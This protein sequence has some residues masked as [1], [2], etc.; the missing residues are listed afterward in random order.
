MLDRV[1]LEIGHEP[2]DVDHRHFGCSSSA[3]TR[4]PS[5][6]RPERAATVRHRVLLL[7]CHLRKGTPVTLSGDEHRVVPESFRAPRFLGDEPLDVAE[8]GHLPAVGPV[9]QRHRWRSGR[10]VRRVG[11]AA[12]RVEQL[13]HVVGV[14]GRLPR[15]AGGPHPGR[16]AE[17]VDLEPGVVGEGREAGRLAQRDRLQPRVVFERDPGLVDVGHVGRAGHQL[18]RQ[19]GRRASSS[20]ISRALSGLAVARTSFNACGVRAVRRPRD[21][22][23]RRSR[24]AV[25]GE[26]EEIVELTPRERRALGGALHLDEATGPGHH[27]VHVDLGPHVF[28]VVEVEVRERV[29]DPHRDRPALIGQ[30]VRR[31]LLLRDQARAHV[32]QRDVPAADR[33]R[34]GYR[35]R[36]AARRSRR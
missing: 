35:R 34:C 17:R 5:S 33:R 29:D 2:R 7:G 9:R 20:V 1:V 22:G 12:E 14:G 16:A 24:D 3:T 13:G 6:Q 26:T 4:S 10:C 11:D 30:R 19:P 21:A 25:L 36:P 27:D 18:E 8:C 32:V 28:G 23:G 31:H 15:V